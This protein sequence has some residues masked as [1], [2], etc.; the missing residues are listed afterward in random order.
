[1]LAQASPV[2]AA[3]ADLF[4]A[5]ARKD[6]AAVAAGGGGDAANSARQVIAPTALREALAGAHARAFQLGAPPCAACC[7]QLLVNSI[8][9][10]LGALLCSP[11]LHLAAV[12]A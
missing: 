1:M 10:Q 11:S 6:A 9:P 5:F 12:L 7:T 8:I 4:R 3:L 2:A